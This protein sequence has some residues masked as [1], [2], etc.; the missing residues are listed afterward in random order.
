MPY[1]KCP[2][3]DTVGF[4]AVRRRELDLC[5]RAA[6]HSAFR[7]PWSRSASPSTALRAIARHRCR[8]R[9]NRQADE[10]GS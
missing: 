3:C 9:P 6:T 1:V 8:R 10:T 2:S 5:P 7:A 4:A